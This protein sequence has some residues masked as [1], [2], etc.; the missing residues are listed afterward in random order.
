MTDPADPDLDAMAARLG[1][2]AALS[3]DR[4]AFA[5]ALDAAASLKARMRQSESFDEEPA[6]VYMPG[7]PRPDPERD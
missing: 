3:I 4:A 1:L 5:S 6:H 7:T 2:A